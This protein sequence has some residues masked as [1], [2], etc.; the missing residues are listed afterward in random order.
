MQTANNDNE[1]VYVSQ[2][3]RQQRYGGP[4]EGGWWVSIGQYTGN[5]FGPFPRSIAM[6]VQ[7]EAREAARRTGMFIVAKSHRMD[8]VY[9]NLEATKGEHHETWE[10]VP[11]ES[12]HYS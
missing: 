1:L 11:R 7:K 2:Y 5:S 10:D 6:V 12:W 4:E 8:D 3:R 9:Y